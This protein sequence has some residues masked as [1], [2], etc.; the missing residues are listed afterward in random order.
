MI[1]LAGFLGFLYNSMLV[2]FIAAHL[3]VG[4]AV[5]DGL[6]PTVGNL[7]LWQEVQLRA[8]HVTT[9]H[10]SCCVSSPT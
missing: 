5:S 4:G 1:S 6:A 8:C 2:L 10:W 3:L 9:H 7:L